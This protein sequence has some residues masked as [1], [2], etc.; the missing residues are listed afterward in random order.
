MR[1]HPFLVKVVGSETARGER[2]LSQEAGE[3]SALR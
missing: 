2:N 1:F 3:V